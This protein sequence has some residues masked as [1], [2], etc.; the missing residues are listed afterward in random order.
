MD[1]APAQV[2]PHW[3]D[4]TVAL[5]PATLAHTDFL[6]RNRSDPEILRYLDREPLASRDE[7]LAFAQRL[8]DDNATGRAAVWLIR[9]QASGQPAGT[10]ALWRLDRANDLG[11]VG[12]TL[13]PEFWGRGYARRALAAVLDHGFGVLGLHRI[14]ANIN[15]D[16]ARS[17]GLLERLGFRLEARLRENYR[18]RG[19]YLDSHIYGLL[20]SE[21]AGACRAPGGS[22]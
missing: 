2:L 12:Y 1:S 19:R 5:E 6:L 16:N 11:E 9:E 22:P 17:R 3:S 4:G 10:V 21:H 13:L 15:P 20:A 18:F 8:V 7:A 14:E